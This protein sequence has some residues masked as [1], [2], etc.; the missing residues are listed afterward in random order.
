ML[1]GEI[2]TYLQQITRTIMQTAASTST[3]TDVAAPATKTVL[4]DD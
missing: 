2:M 3:T 4:L 1:I